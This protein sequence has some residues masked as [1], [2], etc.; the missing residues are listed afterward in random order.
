MWNAVES[1]VVLR[2]SRIEESKL[3]YSEMLTRIEKAEQNRE[4]MQSQK[5]SLQFTIQSQRLQLEQTANKLTE[6]EEEERCI[7]QSCE[8]YSSSM[9]EAR[10]SVSQK[11]VE[12]NRAQCVN[13]KLKKLIEE[14]RTLM[15]ELQ[16]LDTEGDLFQK[17][18]LDPARI[19][20][21]ELKLRFEQ[22]QMKRDELIQRQKKTKETT[23]RVKVKK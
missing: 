17:E 14:K 6:L 2:K 10:E 18:Q 1:D 3:L 5:E 8:D 13:E 16:F 11:K 4:V 19:M 7:H 15:S 22:L 9:I 20:I 21:N 23:N 12:L